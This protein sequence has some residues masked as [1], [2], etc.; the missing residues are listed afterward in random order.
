MTIFIIIFAIALIAPV[1]ITYFA[2]RNR[3]NN[4]SKT[5]DMLN[6]LIKNSS[7]DKQREAEKRRRIEEKNKI[8][9]KVERA[10]KDI[11]ESM[12]PS[13][14]DGVRLKGIRGLR[15]YQIPVI[16]LFED[17]PKEILIISC[18]LAMNIE[19]EITI[20]EQ[21]KKL[22]KDEL[23][24]A[25]RDLQHRTLNIVKLDQLKQKLRQVIQQQFSDI[26][27]SNLTLIKSYQDTQQQKPPILNNHHL[28]FTIKRES[29]NINLRLWLNSTQNHQRYIELVIKAFITFHFFQKLIQRNAP[30][31][32]TE[33]YDFFETFFI[34]DIKQI[35]DSLEI[36]LSQYLITQGRIT[37]QYNIQDSQ[38]PRSIA[39]L[40]Q[41]PESKKSSII[42]DEAVSLEE[43]KD[44]DSLFGD[45]TDLTIDKLDF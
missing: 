15:E 31:T 11:Q 44:I 39:D 27:I 16:N 43:N 14:R 10:K 45:S 25:C 32:D 7:R 22:I 40:V 18:V 42:K 20:F 13:H 6:Y 23:T 37:A 28:A 30:P 12:V 33:L 5:P 21:L 19:D 17:Q 29:L 41:K 35:L 1:F 4:I 2:I 38:K 26:Q 3:R 34:H 36:T 8:D 9:Q 24:V